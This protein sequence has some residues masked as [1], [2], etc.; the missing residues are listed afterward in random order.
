MQ[1]HLANV[2]A[3]WGLSGRTTFTYTDAD[4]AMSGGG[5][6]VSRSWLWDELEQLCHQGVVRR[7]AGESGVWMI[8]AREQGDG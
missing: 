8:L 6:D 7:R 2:V 5:F 4:R 3:H 1:E